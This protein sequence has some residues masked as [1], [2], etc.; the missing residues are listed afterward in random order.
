L[1]SFL[2]F[3]KEVVFPPDDVF[4]KHHSDD[5]SIADEIN[6]KVARVYARAALSAMRQD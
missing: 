5:M 1:V 2:V 4:G 6:F 3:S